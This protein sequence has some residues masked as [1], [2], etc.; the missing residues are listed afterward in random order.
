MAIVAG[1]RVRRRVVLLDR[2]WGAGLLGNPLEGTLDRRR[3][4]WRRGD[5]SAGHLGAVLI[6]GPAHGDRGAVRRVVLHG[7]LNELRLVGG[8]GVLATAA[9]PLEYAALGLVREGIVAA[10]VA[11]VARLAH[12]LLGLLEVAL[13]VDQPE[14]GH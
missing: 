3:D 9:F 2:F 10:G 11:E 7:A 4:G 5:V 6:G 12:D 1:D 13:A 14:Q 8:A